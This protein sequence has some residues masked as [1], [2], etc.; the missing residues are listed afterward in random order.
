M[1]QIEQIRSGLN[2][3]ARGCSA[4][5]EHAVARRWSGWFTTVEHT[6]GSASSQQWWAVRHEIS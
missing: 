5:P 6:V 2:D 3:Y 1:T 4:P